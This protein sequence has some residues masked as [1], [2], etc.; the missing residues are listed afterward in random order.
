MIKYIAVG[1]QIIVLLYEIIVSRHKFDRSME[2]GHLLR[3]VSYALRGDYVTAGINIVCPFALFS[4]WGS[5]KGEK[6]WQRVVIFLAP[7]V[8]MYM[9]IG[10]AFI[11]FGG[12]KQLLPMITGMFE[13]YAA[14]TIDKEN[15]EKQR[16]F[17]MLCTTLFGVYAFISGAWIIGIAEFILMRSMHVPI[18]HDKSAVGEDSDKS[19]DEK[20]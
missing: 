5:D 11:A 19:T 6:S 3:A 13:C 7:G 15:R 4:S 17:K 12:I 20:L 2:A 16:A 1:A 18:H 9:I 10:F 14:W 8:F